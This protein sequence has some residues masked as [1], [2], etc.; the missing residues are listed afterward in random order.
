MSGFDPLNPWHPISDAV[1]LKTLG[2]LVEELG[3]LQA[4]LARCII[5][6]VDEV[7]PVTKKPNRRWL[8][9]EIADVLGNI[10]LVTEF[11]KLNKTFIGVRRAKKIKRLREWH[12]M[13]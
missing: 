11:L 4:A 9:E 5:Q 8:E 2:K 12:R 3:E 13:A 7:E 10:Q 1:A 6:G